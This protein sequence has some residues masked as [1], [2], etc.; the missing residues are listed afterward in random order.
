MHVPANCLDI[1]KVTLGDSATGHY[2]YDLP[3]ITFV[4][5]PEDEGDSAGEESFTTAQVLAL[6]EAL[7]DE[8]DP[9]IDAADIE[10]TWNE[11]DALEDASL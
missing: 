9:V 8:L 11:L 6:I 1:D 10:A 2:R 3:L 7:T 4:V 5:Q